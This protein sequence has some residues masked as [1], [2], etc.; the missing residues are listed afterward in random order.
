MSEVLFCFFC[1]VQNWNICL[2]LLIISQLISNL[3]HSTLFISILTVV[4]PYFV[5]HCG[6]KT[7]KFKFHFYSWRNCSRN[8]LLLGPITWKRSSLCVRHE[9]HS[10]SLTVML[11]TRWCSFSRLQASASSCE[12]VCLV[13][14]YFIYFFY[15]SFFSVEHGCRVKPLRRT[16][17]AG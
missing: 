9:I 4:T 15:T 3:Q 16:R 11:S 13:T 7:N 17:V 8:D 6:I 1:V 10:L 2:F 14:I 5:F 12:M